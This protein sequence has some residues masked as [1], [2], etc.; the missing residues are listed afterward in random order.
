VTPQPESIRRQKL[1]LVVPHFL[2]RRKGGAEQIAYD[3]AKWLIRRGHAVRVVC[4][5]EVEKGDP[6]GIESATDEYEDIPVVRLTIRSRHMAETPGLQAEWPALTQF[7]GRL[8]RDE[9]P[10]VVHLLSG[11][12]LG[13]AALA[14]ARDAA[15]PVVVTLLD[16]WFICP[17]LHLKRGDGTLCYGPDPLECVRCV[18]D[19]KR[20][21]R[22]VDQAAPGVMRSFWRVAT[23]MPFLGRRLGLFD[24]LHALDVRQHQLASL[25]GTAR[26]IV[27][28]TAFVAERHRE[29]GL[30]HRRILVMS[31]ITEQTAGHRPAEPVPSLRFGYLGQLSPDKGVHL[32]LAAFCALRTDSRDVS[33]N[34]HGASNAPSRYIRGLQRLARR[35]PN[36]RLSGPYDRGRVDELLRDIDV[37]V[38]PSTWHENA[39]LVIVEA[40]TAGVPVIG[41]DVRGIAE[42]VRHDVNG[43]LFARAD[44]KD[45]R[46][47]MQKLIDQPPLLHQ[48][49]AGIPRVRGLDEEMTDLMALYTDST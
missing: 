4:V 25:L 43:L 35:S 31:P 13:P 23:R 3:T 12:L 48:L 28:R 6:E 45:L 34:V 27:S 19:R 15:I 7:F 20:R 24:T 37:L 18:Y 42:L 2:P 39:P 11:Y 17:T 41:S 44:G 40:F 22:M 5:E 9:R 1:L 10:D 14:A 30:V 26:T 29:N 32:L 36:V 16:F 46:R 49:R 8:L 21:Y 33:L 47:Q 38:V